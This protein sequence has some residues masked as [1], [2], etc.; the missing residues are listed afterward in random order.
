M[1]FFDKT[2]FKLALF[3]AI[4]LSASPFK[5]GSCTKGVVFKIIK[6]SPLSK[7]LIC[8]LVKSPENNS[9]MFFSVKFVLDSKPSNG[10]AVVIFFASLYLSRIIFKS[11]SFPL[12]SAF[13]IPVATSIVIALMPSILSFLIMSEANSFLWSLN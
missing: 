7:F 12:S 3:E 6:I 1:Y 2:D 5:L 4:F 8:V 13:L 11:F 9:C 10:F